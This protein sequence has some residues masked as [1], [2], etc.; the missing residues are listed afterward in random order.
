MVY[1]ARQTSPGVR[2]AANRDHHG[3]L[4]DSFYLM[5]LNSLN[6][7]DSV[8]NVDILILVP[9]QHSVSSAFVHGTV[10]APGRRHHDQPALP[11]S[12]CGNL[13]RQAIRWIW[14]R[15]IEL[16]VTLRLSL[17]SDR[18]QLIDVVSRTTSHAGGAEKRLLTT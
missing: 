13:C 15:K 6:H 12:G 5:I 9:P 14:Q 18:L 11:V 1:K 4:L 7:A 8:T 10:Y 16:T 2:S 17:H 3:L